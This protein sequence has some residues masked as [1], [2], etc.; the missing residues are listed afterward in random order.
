MPNK[1]AGAVLSPVSE[2]GPRSLIENRFEESVI[3]TS[4]DWI[5]N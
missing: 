5:M 3:V 2:L 1:P 4:A